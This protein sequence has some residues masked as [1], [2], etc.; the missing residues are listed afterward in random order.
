[1]DSLDLCV[2]W[3]DRPMTGEQYLEQS[4]A[5]LQLLQA[6]LPVFSQLYLI[7][8]SGASTE[9]L[10]LGSGGFEDQVAR[11]LPSD[12]AYLNEDPKNKAFRPTSRSRSGFSSAFSNAP[13]GSE[14]ACVIEIAC[15]KAD[16]GSVNSVIVRLPESLEA[17]Q[18]VAELFHTVAVFWTATHGSASRPWFDDLLDQPI[19][20]VRVGWLTYVPDP[21]AAASVPV[22]FQAER[23]GEGALIRL[24]GPVPAAEDRVALQSLV[25]LRDA[26]DPK[27]FLRN[28]RR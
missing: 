15:G 28:P 16:K 4:K 23:L 14:S 1:M 8:S 11:A 3:Y 20:D 6:R 10:D 21:N 5:F 9:P 12:W 2:Y 24:E 17:P 22:G 13:F 7:S 19:G 18:F 26:L 25:R 27:G